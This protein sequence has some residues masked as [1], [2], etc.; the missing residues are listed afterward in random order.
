MDST[1]RNMIILQYS[2]SVQQQ[3]CP[4][5]HNYSK[6]T[7][8]VVSNFY[9]CFKCRDNL[10]RP[11]RM[12]YARTKINEGAQAWTWFR[13]LKCRKM[14]VTNFAMQPLI[15]L[16]AWTCPDWEFLFQ[17]GIILFDPHTVLMVQDPWLS[18]YMLGC[19]S[20]YIDGLEGRK[21]VL[22]SVHALEGPKATIRTPM[23]SGRKICCLYD[24]ITKL[25]TI[26]APKLSAG[27]ANKFGSKKSIG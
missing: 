15:Y 17:T 27:I 1:H 19:P 8:T 10:C 24:R 7:D 6:C 16:M 26:L 22:S 25:R 13:M 4:K 18:L 9:N 14:N 5:F 11:A 20:G 21:A 2:C 3:S 12:K 23:M